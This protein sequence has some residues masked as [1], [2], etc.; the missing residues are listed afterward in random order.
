MNLKNEFN[1]WD[2]FSPWGSG[3]GKLTSLD[4]VGQNF[5]PSS[6]IWSVWSDRLG[7]QT[8]EAK[9]D[10]ANLDY[11]S[12]LRGDNTFDMLKKKTMFHSKKLE[13]KHRG[14]HLHNKNRCPTAALS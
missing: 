2:S 10:V 4:F 14:V 12:R 7:L 1:H 3:P 13:K 5:V 11:N 9:S 8:Y 6:D